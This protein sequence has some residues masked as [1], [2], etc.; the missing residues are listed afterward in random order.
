MVLKKEA[1]YRLIRKLRQHH[2][3]TKSEIQELLNE[4]HVKVDTLHRI[5]THDEKT[6]L[7]NYSFFKEIFVIEIAQASRGKP[8]SV[9]LTDIDFFK[10]IN[11]VYGHVFADMLL[12][13]VS[14]V[15]LKEL[16]SYDVLARFGGEEFVI[17]L[18]NTSLKGAR[19]AAEHLRKSILNDV[20]LSRY[21]LT[22][23]F[24]VDSFKK[25]DNLDILLER[26]DKALY[27][28]KREGRNLVRG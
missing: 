19:K 5:A 1:I 8:L 9:I 13:R 20:V 22:M 17:M 23:S 16:R 14:T 28:A 11:D 7:H 26:A 12:K 24:G 27:K 10:K 18:P 15:L 25:G 2:S 4:L 3:L 21:K 6:G